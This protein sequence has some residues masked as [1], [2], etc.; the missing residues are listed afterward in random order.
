MTDDEKKNGWVLLFDGK[1]T[2]GW[3]LYN[4]GKVPSVWIVKNDELYC[5]ANSNREQGDLTSDKEFENFDLQ[6]DWKIEKM[7][8]SGVFINVIERPD[9]KTTYASGPEY[10]ILEKSHPDYPDSSK[11]SGCMFG[12]GPQKN[13]VG[14]TNFNEWYHSR[15]K[16]LNGKTEFYLDGVLTAEQDFTSQAWLDKVKQSNFKNYAEFGKHTKGHIALQQ[17]AKSISF[18]NIKIKEL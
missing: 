16:Q 2:D 15:I 11:R 18:R 14:A 8:N 17:W 12:F 7:G 9:I 10:Q 6:F 1:S 5:D 3:H 4:R 13:A